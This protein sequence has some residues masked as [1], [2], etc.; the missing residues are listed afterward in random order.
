MEI[1]YNDQSDIEK[2]NPVQFHIPDLDSIRGNGT[3]FPKW[4]GIHEIPG[5]LLWGIYIRDQ[6]TR[7]GFHD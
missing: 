4:S 5:R 1:T 3:H 2:N 7:C 6:K